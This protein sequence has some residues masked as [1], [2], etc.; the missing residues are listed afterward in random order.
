[1]DN[2]NSNNRVLLVFLAVERL[3]THWLDRLQHPPTAAREILPPGTAKNLFTLH[4]CPPS[5]TA[6]C[7]P[8]RMEL[9]CRV[10]LVSPPPALDEVQS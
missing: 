10:E 8:Q 3:R 6:P 7:P 5:R 2:G 9:A 1:V 4:Y